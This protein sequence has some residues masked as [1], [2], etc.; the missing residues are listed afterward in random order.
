MYLF[1]LAFTFRSLFT[2]RS[3]LSTVCVLYSLNFPQPLTIFRSAS[4]TVYFLFALRHTVYLQFAQR[5][6]GKS[7]MFQGLYCQIQFFFRFISQQCI[8]NIFIQLYNVIQFIVHIDMQYYYSS[9][10][11]L[12]SKTLGLLTTNINHV[13][14]KST[15]VLP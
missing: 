9:P 2:L 1:H 13:P 11:T 8:L 12:K 3:L 10:F 4:H 6:N 14:Y 5:L 7:K 15:H